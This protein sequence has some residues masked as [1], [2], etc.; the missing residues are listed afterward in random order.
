MPLYVKDQDIW[1]RIRTK[2][3]L[4]DPSRL[5]LWSWGQN[6]VGQLSLNH[7][8]DRSVPV[9]VQAHSQNPES[10]RDLIGGYHTIA[11]KS[12]G[13][14]WGWG[15]NDYGQIGDGTIQHRS[16]PVR[17][18]SDSDWELLAGNTNTSYGIKSNGT[19]WSWG[20]SGNGQLGLSTYTSKSTPT[21]IGSASSWEVIGSGYHH[22]F[23]KNSNQQLYSCGRNDYGQLGLGNTIE[24]SSLVYVSLSHNK[25]ISGGVA[26]TLLLGTDGSLWSV[27]YDL[28]GQLGVNTNNVHR[29]NFIQVGTATDWKKICCGGYH[30]LAIKT[31]GTLW[32]WGSN[33]NG[34]CG[35]NTAYL[36]CSVPTQVGGDSDWTHIG[37]GSHSSF[38][39]RDD[40]TL[41]S[42]GNNDYGQLGINTVWNRPW[43]TRV[44]IGTNWRAIFVS[45]NSTL[46]LRYE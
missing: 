3:K 39:I 10:W 22:F 43:P 30:N 44:G 29:S 12:D 20:Y 19:L 8:T 26:H 34:Q 38:G 42:W 40:G 6:N 9:Q 35:Y 36:H 14:L 15:W 27:G 11:L 5:R 45:G 41:W 16:E 18:E 4:A 23:A 24:R 2:E 33:G 46:G 17:I 21:R 32:S 13:T 1:K 37:C 31:N 28:A 25:E 7:T